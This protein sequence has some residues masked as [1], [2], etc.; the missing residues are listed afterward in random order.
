MYCFQTKFQLDE[1]CNAL[2]MQESSQSGGALLTRI[3]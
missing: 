2:G 3:L 1:K